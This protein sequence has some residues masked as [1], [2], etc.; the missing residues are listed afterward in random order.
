MSHFVS[1][2]VVWESTQYAEVRCLC[3]NSF[4]ITSPAPQPSAAKNLKPTILNRSFLTPQKE[5]KV[6]SASVCKSNE[7]T[8]VS[9]RHVCQMHRPP[10]V[11]ASIVSACNYCSSFSSPSFFSRL[12]TTCQSALTSTLQPAALHAP[13]EF[14]SE[15]NPSFPQYVCITAG[16][17]Y[18]ESW[19]SG[20]SS[21]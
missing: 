21:C 1:D 8:R 6:R 12:Q 18:F 11:P 16:Q 14:E 3:L 5:T 2:V 7:A 17:T 4:D 20:K 13:A 10:G 9:A 19:S 15:S